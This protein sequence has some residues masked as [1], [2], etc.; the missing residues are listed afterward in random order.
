MTC[1]TLNRSQPRSITP[2]VVLAFV[3]LSVAYTSHAILQHGQYAEQVRKCLEQQPPDIIMHNPLTGRDALCV[4]L[5]DGKF[6]VQIVDGEK[7]VTSFPN[8][9]TTIEKLAHYLM[10]AGYSLP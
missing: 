1:I 2:L 4:K 6:G 9:S 5:P 7:E 3:L 8:K 10:N